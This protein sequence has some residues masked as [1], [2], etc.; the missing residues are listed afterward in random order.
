MGAGD[1]NPGPQ[2][3]KSLLLNEVFVVCLFVLLKQSL[4]NFGWPGAHCVEEVCLEFSLTL[5]TPPPPPPVPG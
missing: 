1:L 2:V 4:A 3:S 5:C